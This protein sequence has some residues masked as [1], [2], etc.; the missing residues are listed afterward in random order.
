ME[1]TETTPLIGTWE[2]TWE[3]REGET[4]K[5]RFVFTTNGEFEDIS[6]LF[7]DEYYPDRP[8]VVSGRRPLVIIAKGSYQATASTITFFCN[9]IITD[10]VE[11]IPPD[12][13]PETRNYSVTRNA[14]TLTIKGT[15]YTYKRVN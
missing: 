9:S 14:M 15:P 8:G 1:T 12:I 6:E 7:T 3:D 4:S 11:R 10:G 2:D 13:V 5:Q